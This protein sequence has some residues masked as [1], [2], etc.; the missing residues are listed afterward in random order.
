MCGL[1]RKTGG[2][3]KPHDAND[4]GFFGAVARKAVLYTPAR[5]STYMLWAVFGADYASIG[6]VGST[7]TS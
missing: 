1:K 7:R 6:P 3:G 5:R 4:P 2:L